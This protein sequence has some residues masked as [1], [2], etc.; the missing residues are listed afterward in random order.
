MNPSSQI[1]NLLN[2]HADIARAA[3]IFAH[4]AL[5]NAALADRLD[6]QNLQLKQQLE[7]MRDELTIGAIDTGLLVELAKFSQES[8]EM[9]QVR[10]Y[11]KLLG[12]NKNQLYNSDDSS[13]YST[14][15]DPSTI[16]SETTLTSVSTYSSPGSTTG[17]VTQTDA[18]P[19]R[20][21]SKLRKSPK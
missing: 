16:S 14:M 7:K 13:I 11:E 18:S 2:E 10:E 12:K 1:R 8:N 15:S 6:E 21:P 19:T 3:N 5:E 20:K 17:D 4:E 9:I